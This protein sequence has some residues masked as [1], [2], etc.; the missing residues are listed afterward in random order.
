MGDLSEPLGPSPIIGAINWLQETLLGTMAV[1]IAVVAVALVGY[2]ALT[3][4]IDWRRG[5][6]VILGC[7]VLFGASAIVSGIRSAIAYEPSG[8]AYADEHINVV[9][10]EP[11][12]LPQLPT[13]PTPTNSDPYAGAALPSH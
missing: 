2:G 11:I 9:S 7:F 5:A 10:P 1:T 6:T 13:R 8:E 12:V 4:R 3:G